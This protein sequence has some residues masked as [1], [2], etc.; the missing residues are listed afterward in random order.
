MTFKGDGFAGG[1][2]GINGSIG[3]KGAGG[4]GVTT[5]WINPLR[6]RHS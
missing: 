1:N 3:T 4:F 5:N 6:S 2:R